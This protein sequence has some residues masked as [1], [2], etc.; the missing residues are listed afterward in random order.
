MQLTPDHKTAAAMWDVPHRF[1]IHEYTKT[2]PERTITLIRTNS[3]KIKRRHQPI[4]E[5][6]YLNN[7]H[8]H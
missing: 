5:L 1:A 4:R 2:V 6:K 3:I 8:E 7:R